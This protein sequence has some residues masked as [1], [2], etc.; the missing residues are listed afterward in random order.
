MSEISVMSQVLNEQIANM[1]RSIDKFSKVCSKVIEEF[2]TCTNETG[3]EVTADEDTISR[4][5]AIDAAIKAVDEW[6]GGFNFTRASIIKKALNA[7]PPSPTP[8]VM[9]KPQWIPCSDP[10]EIPKDKMLWV[11]HDNGYER[12]VEVLFWDMTEWSDKVSDV[13]AYMPYY[14]P[15]PYKG[16]DA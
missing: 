4:K 7:L 15:Q 6:D 14:E 13:V 8:T 10:S 16:V 11:T 5:Q 9:P 12:Y 1:K 3:N 2:G